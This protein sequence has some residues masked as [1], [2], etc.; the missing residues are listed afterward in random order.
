MIT[1]HIHQKYMFQPYTITYHYRIVLVVTFM[2]HNIDYA[3]NLNHI[4]AA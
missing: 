3:L 2:T 1:F 4:H